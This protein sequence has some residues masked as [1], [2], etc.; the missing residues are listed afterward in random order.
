MPQDTNTSQTSSSAQDKS[1]VFV[2]LLRGVVVVVRI[3]RCSVVTRI[4]DAVVRLRAAGRRL[5]VRRAVQQRVV[6]ADVIGPTLIA[7][8]VPADGALVAV[9]VQKYA[10]RHV[11]EHAL[12]PRCPAE[13]IFWEYFDVPR[14][15]W[16]SKKS[17]N[18][19]ST[20]SVGLA[21]SVNRIQLCT[22]YLGVRA[23]I[24]RNFDLHAQHK[25][26]ITITRR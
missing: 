24:C 9:L 5:R 3:M 19:L 14:T 8:R 15:D 1:S 16:R 7:R 22:C 11:H 13:V 21:M 23:G 4:A 2:I 26:I 10:V 18:L 25:P 20:L 12:P 17:L 6:E